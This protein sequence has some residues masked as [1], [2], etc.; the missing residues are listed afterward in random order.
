MV[1]FCVS[2]WKSKINSQINTFEFKVDLSYLISSG[3][4]Q[5]NNSGNEPQLF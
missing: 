3:S 5:S 1:T 4:P 2:K